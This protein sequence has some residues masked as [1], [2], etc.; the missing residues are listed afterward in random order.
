[1]RDI[2]AVTANEGTNLSAVNSLTDPDDQIATVRVTLSIHSIEQLVGTM[3]K[4]RQLRNVISVE[5]VYDGTT[6]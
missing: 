2:T 4:L 5:R 3:D 6:A 1:M